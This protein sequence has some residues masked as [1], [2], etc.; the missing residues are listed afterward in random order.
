MARIQNDRG[1]RQTQATLNRSPVSPVG[2]CPS[3]SRPPSPPSCPLPWPPSSPRRRKCR[4]TGGWPHPDTPG[5]RRS[6]PRSA[7][8]IGPRRS[9]SPGGPLPLGPGQAE[10]A[11]E[12]D[13]RALVV[14]F[15]APGG[16]LDSAGVGEGVT[17]SWSMICRVWWGPSARHS[18]ETDSSGRRAAADRSRAAPWPSSVGRPSTRWFHG[19]GSRV[20][21]R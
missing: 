5:C 12:G 21:V 1:G 20:R 11:G 15:A 8:S 6:P 18:P 17:A 19:E 14:V 2:C 16:V 3:P 13:E 10:L 4:D 9:R 7:R